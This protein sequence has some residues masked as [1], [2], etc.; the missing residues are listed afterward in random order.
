MK[1]KPGDQVIVRSD[2]RNGACYC[3]EDGS[4]H[5]VAIPSMLSLRGRTVTIRQIIQHRYLIYGSTLY[6]TD[7]M[8]DGAVIEEEQIKISESEKKA[9]CSFLEA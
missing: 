1:Y 5:T 8:F 7:G 6:W 3:A 2:L 4:A 9:I